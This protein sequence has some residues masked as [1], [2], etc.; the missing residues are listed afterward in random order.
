MKYFTYLV[1]AIVA[2]A[3][4]A[5][6]FV[7]GSPNQER[8]RKFDERRIQD[9][10]FIQSEIINYWLK[11]GELVKLLPLLED[12]VRGVTIPK[13][14]LVGADYSYE[15]RDAA[16]LKFAL[17]ADFALPSLS[18]EQSRAPKMAY[19][20]VGYYSDQNWEH[21]AG[22]VCFERTID[23]EIYRPEPKR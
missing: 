14:P 21:N 18:L 12:S 19:P 5:G 2:G 7:V 20:V 23:P 6:F 10:Q 16:S 11:K 22:F 1:I 9:L 4:I 15:L 17:C 13:D 3:V 8:L